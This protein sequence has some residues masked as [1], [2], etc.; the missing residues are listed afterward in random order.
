MTR[1]TDAETRRRGA[2][3]HIVFSAFFSAPPR[4]RVRFSA[5]GIP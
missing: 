2:N 4:L 3:K 5:P 1:K